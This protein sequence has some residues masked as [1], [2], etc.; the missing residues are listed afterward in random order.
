MYRYFFRFCVMTLTIL[1]ANLLTGVI[2]GWMVSYKNDYKPLIFTFIGM[3]IIVVVF[4]PLFVKLES[5]VREISVKAI[6]SGRSLGGKYLG[7]LFTFIL[8]LLVLLY[9]YAKMWYNIDVFQVLIHGN[10]SRYI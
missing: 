3:M 2:T 9:F 7:L 4:Y 6:R 10:I 5:W 8:G 1:A